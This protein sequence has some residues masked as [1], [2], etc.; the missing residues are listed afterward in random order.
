[1]SF[2]SLSEASCS[3]LSVSAPIPRTAGGVAAVQCSAVQS[4]EALYYSAFSFSL[5]ATLQIFK[6]VSTRWQTAW[7]SLKIATDIIAVPGTVMPAGSGVSCLSL[8]HIVKDVGKRL[9]PWYCKL[10]GP[11]PPSHYHCLQKAPDFLYKM[12]RFCVFCPIKDPISWL[13]QLQSTTKDKL[14][15]FLLR[16]RRLL[17]KTVLVDF[18]NLQF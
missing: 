11:R 4:A 9:Q 17:S 5:D 3:G 14:I 8:K 7:R 10:P 13:C 2:L 16:S 18:Y 15:S 12:N 6:W 1:M